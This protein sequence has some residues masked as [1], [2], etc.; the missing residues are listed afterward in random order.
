MICIHSDQ[1]DFRRAG[2]GELE[3]KTNQPTILPKQW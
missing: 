2:K 3:I 1:S